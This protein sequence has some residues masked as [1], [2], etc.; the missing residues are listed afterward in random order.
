MIFRHF[1]QNCEVFYEFSSRLLLDKAALELAKEK[2]T[3]TPVWAQSCH[4]CFKPVS[5]RK[6]AKPYLT[7]RTAVGMHQSI[8]SV[9]RRSG[10]LSRKLHIN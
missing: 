6:G 2:G 3:I 9:Y 8:H 10:L 4:K 1:F 5:A 7:A